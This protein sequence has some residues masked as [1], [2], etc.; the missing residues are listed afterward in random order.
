[1]SDTP[2][3]NEFESRKDRPELDAEGRE[4]DRN[5]P[6]V[7]ARESEFLGDVPRANESYTADDMQR[8]NDL[9]HVRMRPSMYIGDVAAQ[10]LH[11][12]VNEVVDNSLD[13]AVAGY[14]TMIAVTINSDGSVTVEDDGRGIPIDE[15]PELGVSTLEGVMT[16]LKFGG[17][18]TKGAYQT[19]GGLHGVGVTVV[20]FLSEWCNVE[21]CRDG[22]VWYQ[23]Y[24]LGVPT[25]PVTQGVATD[26]HGTK[27]TFKPDHTIFQNVRFDYDI[28]HHRLRDLA[29]LN[30][31]ITIKFRDLRDG[32]HEEF[33]YKN[34]LVDFVHSLNGEAYAHQD[35]L[36]AHGMQAGVQV[37]IALQY[38]SGYNE[39]VRTYVNNVHTVEG[40][41]HLSGFRRALTTV[42]NK[43]G[44]KNNF[45][46][47][48]SPTGEDF[49]EGLTAVLS[50]RVPNPLF[51][52]QTKTK[53]GNTEVEGIVTSIFGDYLA[54]Y[55]EEHPETARIIM[56]KAITAAEARE[57]AKKA[58]E[59]VH[60]RKSALSGGGM[61]GKLR[62]CTS[63]D[64]NK[65][66]LY[67][68]EG[69]S[70]GGSAEGGRLREFQ[71]ILPLR[72]KVIN[73]H[74][75]QEVR[76]L[77]NE[78]IQS[79]I[80]AIGVG[81]GDNVDLS[82]RRYSKI[83]I[84]TDADV[85]G[86]HIRTLLLTFFYNQMYMLVK[87][88]F[89]F[90]ALPPLY[91][92]RRKNSKNGAVK[93]LEN[94]EEMDRFLLLEGLK[95][96]QFDPQDGRVIEGADLE[97]LCKLL[98]EFEKSLSPLEKIGLGPQTLAY[99]QN[100]E[101]ALVPIYRVTWR[102]DEQW[103]YER[104]E[105]DEYIAKIQRDTGAVLEEVATTS[106]SDGFEVQE[107]FDEEAVEEDKIYLEA[108][109]EIRTLN[110]LLTRLR[111]EFGFELDSLFKIERTG[112]EGSRYL[113]RRDDSQNGVENLRELLV[114][115]RSF[116]EKGW[117]I[118]RFK[119][120]GEMDPEEL[121]ETTL[122]PTRR[123][124]EQVV[125]RDSEVADVEQTFMTL[126][127]E[128]VAPRRNFI[129]DNAS[130]AQLDV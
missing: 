38:S 49:R 30:P 125:M 63:R 59:M 109:N 39:T 33:H 87:E 23:E 77:K 96:A 12:L 25:C 81:Y 15:H 114:A 80:T 78:E 104:A 24:E 20:N 118:T 95:D 57:S 55:L 126:M 70:A 35:V 32:R 110:G 21:V 66:E 52:G 18:F 8:L 37:D 61:P 54:T 92:I 36:R 9:E 76:V 42:L 6:D 90:A 7:A 119:G 94:K 28:L 46:K 34:G 10:G 17:K 107:E 105:R 56:Q 130:R 65:C 122:D 116:G 103:F 2:A 11:H 51:Q 19:S 117:H 102:N 72:G 40:G 112:E 120:L 27:T 4:L 29:F 84:M 1:M 3:A 108:F 97:N 106:V 83:V 101:T 44:A 123:R 26:R 48:I 5:E 45:Y 89:V 73:T 127:G 93:Y 128:E 88:G 98:V 111:N 22:Y 60:A 74:K 115:I 75:A 86:S 13:E 58:R 91:R 64:V 113:V 71:A 62:D 47:N 16:V 99:V 129:I 79:M 53:L 85:D 43:Y 41:T 67:L 82:K 31:R 100:P 69:N 124:L 121:R 68:V 14:A 50:V